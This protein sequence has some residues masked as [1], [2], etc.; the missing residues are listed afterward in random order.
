MMYGLQATF[1]S[2]LFTARLRY[3]GA[4]LGYQIGAVFGGAFAPLISAALY[5]AFKSSAPIAIY[6]VVICAITFV[7]V[8]LLSET[9]QTD[10]DDAK[11]STGAGESSVGARGTALD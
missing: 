9:Y 1:Y 11:Q 3:S 5:A 4:S 10:V 7:S 2:E 6:M 8:Y